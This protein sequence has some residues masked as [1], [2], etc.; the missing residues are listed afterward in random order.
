MPVRLLVAD[1]IDHQSRNEATAL[2]DQIDL[3][4]RPDCRY[5]NAYRIAR[6]W[7]QEQTGEFTPQDQDRLIGALAR[8]IERDA[9]AQRVFAFE[10]APSSL[11]EESDRSNDCY[12]VGVAHFTSVDYA[13]M[14]ITDASL[15]KVAGEVL[16][17]D[18]IDRKERF[19]WMNPDIE[20]EPWFQA[21]ISPSQLAG[22]TS[23]TIDSLA[24]G[25]FENIAPYPRESIEL[26]IL[27]AGNT[28]D[29]DLD[30]G[31]QRLNEVANFGQPGIVLPFG[32][33]ELQGEYLRLKCANLDND[34]FG[35]QEGRA[36]TPKEF[37]GVVDRLTAAHNADLV[38]GTGMAVYDDRPGKNDFAVSKEEIAGAMTMT[39]AAQGSVVRGPH[40]QV[41][42]VAMDHLQER[43]YMLDG[44]M[45]Q[46]VARAMARM[47]KAP[48]ADSQVGRV[49]QVLM[50]V[51][52][53]RTAFEKAN[54]GYD[55][56]GSA[57]HE[58]SPAEKM[59][60]E[61]GGKGTALQFNNLKFE[62]NERYYCAIGAFDRLDD[63]RGY[64]TAVRQAMYRSTRDILEGGL[65]EHLDRL[66]HASPI[67]KEGLPTLEEKFDRIQEVG[68]V[69]YLKEAN[70]R[71]EVDI[72]AA[73]LRS[74]GGRGR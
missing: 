33:A 23:D 60:D 55:M 35:R 17:L 10:D 20:Q 28:Q 34:R 15:Q 22:L 53:Q 69:G 46:Q 73:Y 63:E 68:M 19:S 72:Q 50:D 58:I 54:G 27:K 74:A 8:V 40:E 24:A 16:D 26:M 45:N 51:A 32:D 5:G 39:L 65:S 4:E 64:A 47:M 62:S 67:G 42:R 59:A 6:D 1:G 9:E 36:L 21:G 18:V 25:E 3:G 49:Q 48:M 57:G 30:R 56:E 29:I 52:V 44:Q 14:L 43:G 38:R 2:I 61:L 7:T 70:L 12:P 66:C 31:L 13:R 37:E 11:E 41:A 71:S